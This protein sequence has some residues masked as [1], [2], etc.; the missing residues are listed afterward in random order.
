MVVDFSKRRNLDNKA[1]SMFDRRIGSRLD[2]VSKKSAISAR[3]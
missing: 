2:R 3:E 1:S